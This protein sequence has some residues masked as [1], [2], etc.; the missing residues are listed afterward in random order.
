MRFSVR[1]PV[2]SEQIQLQLP[3]VSTACRRR[4]MARSRLIF[5]TPIAIMTVT[6]AGIPSGIAATATATADKKPCRSGSPLQKIPTRKR[7][8][9]TAATKAVMILPRTDSAFSSGV[10]AAS[11][12]AR[13]PAIWPISVSL[14][15]PTTTA[16][17]LPRTT[18]EEEYSIHRR[19]ASGALSGTGASDLETPL[20]SPVSADSSQ[21]SS[22]ARRMR[23]SAGIMSPSSNTIRSPGTSARLSKSRSLPP[24]TALTR[25]TERRS[26][27]S[28]AVS[29][30]YCWMNPTTALSSTMS[31]RMPVSVSPPASSAQK[32]TTAERAAA[33]SRRMVMK[34]LNCAR[35]RRNGPPFLRDGRAFSPSR[36]RRDCASASESPTGELCSAESVSD[37]VRE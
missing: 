22:S 14:P 11:V 19:S 13:M 16:A 24:R 37:A 15:V 33:Q 18:K 27:F 1:V 35:N 2:L 3:S 28:T 23:Q 17:A 21:R 8:A 32:A 7:S 10:L 25:Q 5:C 26:S 31:K 9:A 36:C 12:C 20:D 30:R 34:S 6:T 29:A 4:T